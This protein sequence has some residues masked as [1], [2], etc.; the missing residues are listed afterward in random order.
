[1]CSDPVTFGGGRA[2]LKRGLPEAWSARN[3][4]ASSQRR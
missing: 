2:M 4:P 1:M 3:T